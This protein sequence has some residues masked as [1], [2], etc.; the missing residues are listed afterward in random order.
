MDYRIEIFDTDGKRVATCTQSPLLEAIRTRPDEVDILRGLLP[1]SVA[2]LGH[3]YRVRVFVEDALFCEGRVQRV[4]SQWSDSQ[5]LILDRYVSFHEV[6][7]FEAIRDPRDLNTRVSQAYAG[8]PIDAMV[9]HLIQCAPGTIHYT[10]NHTAYPDGAQREYAKFLA[11]RNIHNELGRGGIAQGQWV[12]RSRFSLEQVYAKDGDTIAGL[13]VDGIPWPDIRLMMIDAEETSKNSH[14]IDLHGEVAQWSSATYAASGYKLRGDAAK[15]ALQ[16]LIDTKGIDFIELNPH[17]DASGHYDDRIDVYGRYLAFVYGGGEC[18]NAAQVEC[19]H[20]AVYLYAD[21]AYHD[22]EMALKDY[23]S[24]SSINRESIDPVSTTLSAF[25][26]D[27]GIFEVL[28]ALAYAAN[29]YAWTMDTAGCVSFRHAAAP[30]RV[31]F[32]DPLLTRIG[33]GS[34]SREMTNILYFGGNPTTGAFTKTYR[35]TNSIHEYGARAARLDYYSITIPDDA[36][37]LAAGLLNDLAY[38]EPCG[39]IELYAGDSRIQVGDLVEVRAH[40]LRR[41]EPRVDG[42]WNN[43]FENRMVGRV[44]QITHRFS[45]R[46]MTTFLQLT[47]PFRSVA[48]PLKT[49]VRKQEKAAILFAFRLDDAKV[50]LDM[51]YHMD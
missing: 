43:L 27:S 45:G 22:P 13:I 42:E 41:Y 31:V 15:A 32:Y 30:T 12:G 26:V 40:P 7:E 4:L 29:G 10:V 46:A 2:N 24:Y 38:P 23:Y 49:M 5:K 8:W 51:S 50:G 18:F 34:D 39:I 44:R 19:G 28:T 16:A 17:R 35:S 33:L 37:K 9:K 1:T 20:A 11:R 14:G 25:D 3:G 21:G 48:D 36:D 47:S 6:L